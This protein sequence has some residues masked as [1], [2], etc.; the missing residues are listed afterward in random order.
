MKKKPEKSKQLIGQDIRKLS[1]ADLPASVGLVREVRAELGAEIQAVE[2]RLGARIMGVENSLSS[3]MNSLE[4]RLDSRMDSL[5]S[6]IVIQGKEMDQKFE[7]MNGQLQQVIAS[8]HRA[9]VLMEEQRSENRIVLD[10]IKTMIDRQNR[11]ET[12]I[13]EIRESIRGLGGGRS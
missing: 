8:T 3:R 7:V 4:S 12:D 9:E 11:T 6:K 2:H 5:E 10:G 1:H 13:Q